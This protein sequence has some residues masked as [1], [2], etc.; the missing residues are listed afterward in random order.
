MPVELRRGRRR[1]WL[2][3]VLAVLLAGGA[4]LLQPHVARR[5]HEPL[6]PASTGP[7]LV[8]RRTYAWIDPAR[9]DPWSGDPTERRQLLGYVWYPADAGSDSIEAP[10]FPHLAQLAEQFAAAD[11]RVLRSIRCQ[12]LLD[13]RAVLGEGPFPVLL[14]SPGANLSCL[15]YTCLLEDLASHGYVV[16]GLEHVHEGRGQVLQDG[17]VA[18]PDYQRHMPPLG[19]PTLEE[20]RFFHR[21]SE[22][23]AA[24]AALALE[25]L[26]RLN[27]SDELLAGR[28][29]LARVGMFGHSVGGMAATHA[30]RHADWL[31]ATADLDGLLLTTD[32]ALVDPEGAG[33]R[34][35]FLFMGQPGYDDAQDALL[36]SGTGR[37][38]RVTID[39]AEHM[40]FSDLPFWAPGSRAGKTRRL[41]AMR[42][43]LRAFFDEH[44]AGRPADLIA[45]TAG[46]P[47]VIVESFLDSG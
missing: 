45:G 31:L 7:F 32:A 16:V 35:P 18:R 9:T 26:A 2:V 34:K 22:I 17:T 36:R 11:R 14:F 33:L 20:T 47:G 6:L 1:G 38:Y 40:T 19:T 30:A 15:F 29:D 13:A 43:C 27:A 37:R 42:T 28:L 23:R 39:G 24:D 25:G 46:L 8:G 5:L 3:A 4:W 21:W 44:V 12:A 10:Y 41:A